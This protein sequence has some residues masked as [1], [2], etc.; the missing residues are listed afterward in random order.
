M[1]CSTK[2]S[3]F[4]QCHN[5]EGAPIGFTAIFGSALNHPHGLLFIAVFF[6]IKSQLIAENRFG[7]DQYR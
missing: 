1:V 6:L 3:C 7:C 4:F 2:K 5:Y